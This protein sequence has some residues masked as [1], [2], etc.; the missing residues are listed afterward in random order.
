M[1]T[2]EKKNLDPEPETPAVETPAVETPAVETPAADAALTPEEEKVASAITAKIQDWQKRKDA[3]EKRMNEIR[4]STRVVDAS[5]VKLFSLR[6]GGSVSMKSQEVGLVADWFRAFVDHKQNHNP[7]AYYKLMEISQKLEPIRTDVAGEGQAL[8]PTI[9]YNAIVPLTEDLS[10]IRPNATVIDMTNIKTLD[11]PTI[12]GRPVLTINGEAV[13]KGTSSMTFG[14]LTLTPYNFAAIVPI[15]QEMLDYSPFDTVRLLSQAF[16]ERCALGEDQL[17]TEGTGS[18]QPKGIDA[19]T[20]AKTIDAS[21]GLTFA[22]L[23]AAFYGVTQSH[24]LQGS[25]LMGAGALS[26]VAS[27]K[28]TN[29]RPIFDQ[30]GLY[31]DGLPRIWGRPVLENNFLPGG[32]IFFGNLKAY[33]IGATRSMRIDIA[34][35][36]TIRSTNLWESNMIAVR[37]EE[38][39]DGKV[40]D[41]RAFAE[42]NNA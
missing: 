35:E 13:A 29:G 11:I 31:Q 9:L 22:H 28:D 21:G 34:R 33:Y 15:T 5:D 26:L 12:T 3:H 23:N 41:V 6:R 24:R 8:V 36:A 14:K 19:E 27:L 37:A 17:F 1:T 4:T 32:S 18:S 30:Q 39:I 10:V 2:E 25:W 38:R 20:Y 42:I 7:D 40:A 16:A